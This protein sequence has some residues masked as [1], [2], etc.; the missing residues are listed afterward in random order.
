MS[1]GLLYGLA[2]IALVAMGI[3]L[4]LGA[5]DSSTWLHASLWVKLVK[6]LLLVALGV[7]VYFAALWLLGLRI[8][9]FIKRST[10]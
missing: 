3:A 4:W 7:S 10:N 1:L 5:G 6:L 9:N 2:G 8:Q